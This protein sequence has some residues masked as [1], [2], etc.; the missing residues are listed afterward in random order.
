MYMNHRAHE[1]GGV[2]AATIAGAVCYKHDM[3]GQN[4]LFI[5]VPLIFGGYTGGLLPD[6]DK[7]GT[8]MG[9]KFR[10]LSTLIAHLFGH[11]G[12]THSLLALLIV[13]LLFFIPVIY[14]DGLLKFIYLQFEFGLL[15]GY[16]SHLILDSSTKMGV[17]F[18]YPFIKKKYNI[19]HLTTGKDDFLV[20]CIAVSL[21]AVTLYIFV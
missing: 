13:G 9:K 19:S 21:A 14:L 2:C 6:I 12:A 1:I 10:L 20:S 8:K 15:V 5:C 4:I 18:L 7:T 16:L 3:I 17:P 11:R